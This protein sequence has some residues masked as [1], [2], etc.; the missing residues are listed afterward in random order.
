MSI[1]KL[2][3]MLASCVLLLSVSACSKEG[4]NS[5]ASAEK[6][7]LPSIPKH[8]FSSEKT[9]EKISEKEAK[10]SIK[11]YLNTYHD[12][13][14][15]ID[16]LRDKDE[17]SN[18]EASKL[19]NLIKLADKNDVNFS[20]YISSNTLPKEY[21][22]GSLITNEYVSST[23]Q[24]LKKINIQVQKVNEKSDSDDFSLKDVA[25]IDDLNKQ[26]KN[27]VNGKKQDEVEKFLESKNISTK[28]FK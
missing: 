24:F 23:N 26:Y 25:K 13:F 22:K 28:A 19:N 6:E 17:I 20:K 7:K 15:N 11:T 10:S 18:G 14:E 4:E 2:P 27:E 12:L 9:H 16:R 1:K 3:L 5:K 21:K 8:A